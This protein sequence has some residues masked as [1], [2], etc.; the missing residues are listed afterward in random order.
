VDRV[1]YNTAKQ[2]S[3]VSRQ[4]GTRGT[5]SEIY[6]VTH[7]YFTF[8][9]HK[10]CGDWQA[11]LGITM[12]VHHL[13]WVSMAGEGKRDYP[14]CI[15]YQSPWY[16]EYGYI[17][18]HF[19]RVGVAMT[20]GKAV[21]RVGVI[22][23]I[24]SYWLAFGPNGSGDEMGNRDQAFKDLT[25]WLLHGLIDFDFISES[26]LPEQANKS[27]KGKRLQVGKCEY[28]VILVPNLRTIR[29]TTLEILQNFT[30][31]GGKVII[32]GST[33]EFIDAQLPNHAPVIPQA[34][35]IFWSRQCVLEA[36][37]Q[38][39]ELRIL[40]EQGSLTEKLLHQMR[41]DD[42]DR[43]VFICNTDRNSE[44]DTTVG[45]KG[46]WKV[47]KLDTFTGVGN[48]IS[49][50]T[51]ND[52]TFF[53]YR[54][55]GCGSL[56][57]RLSPS[58]SSPI[59]YQ[60]PTFSSQA[61]KSSTD[62]ALSSITLSEPNIL[63]LDYASYKLDSEPYS[64][65]TEV[66]R[67]DN[68]IRSRLR[69]P[70]KGSAWKQPWTV[71]A[72]ERAPRT[73]VTL[74]FTFT[75][76]FDIIEPTKLALEDPSTMKIQVN[77]LVLPSESV[78]GYWVDEAIKTIPIPANIIKKGTN[79]IL[80]SFPFGILTNIERVYLLG[81]FSVSLKPQPSILPLDLKTLTWGDITTQGLPFYVGNVIYHCNFSLP[82]TILDSKKT[83]TT[84]SVSSF[85]SPVLSIHDTSTNEKLGRIAFQPHTLSLPTDIQSISI[86]A[87]GNRYNAFGHIHLQDGITDQC[88][89]DI[90]RSRFTF[91]LPQFD[92]Q[93]HPSIRHSIFTC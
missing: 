63:M 61:L 54:F 36:L 58:S 74:C 50:Y 47:E 91:F 77:D 64:Q 13:T 57:L 2:A 5:M 37:Q 32:A 90:W 29:S 55:E 72:S 6:G 82:S 92:Y 86:T 11:A 56:L 20:R 70:A 39:R 17:E 59:S 24:E 28:D 85:F 78:D 44:V 52:W 43:F 26:L 33:P 22:H 18:D 3:S 62:I 25:I 89:P 30:G 65:S 46:Q 21:T 40:T 34:K 49:S 71:P 68:I 93:Y 66:L 10:G 73:H 23:P 67:I 42:K 16:K 38:Y 7:W 12:R 60:R 31:A 76:H 15:G 75:S 69:I 51:N 87:F 79:T 81:S 45:L 19:A 41:Q 84:L 88:W 35:S 80:L 4:N 14:A 48:F 1:E 53:P 83:T 8:E 9:G 27:Q